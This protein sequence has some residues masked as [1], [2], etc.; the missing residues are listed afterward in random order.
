MSWMY[1]I[2]AGLTE[3][4]GVV[5]LKRVSDK[6]SLLAYALLIGGFIVSLS[7]LRMALDEIPLSVAY[8]AWTGIGTAGAALIGILF[9]KESK[10]PLR[11]VCIVGI[12]CTVIG[13]RIIG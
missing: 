12:I 10:S 1:L 9:Y 2:L 13:L 8:A 4:I 11:L 7:L 6:G 5:G 3:I